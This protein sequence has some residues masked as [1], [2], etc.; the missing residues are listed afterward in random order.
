MK[1]LRN[2]AIHRVFQRQK[3]PMLV[4]LTERTQDQ[5]IVGARSKHA[6]DAIVR[7]LRQ[8]GVSCD[9]IHP[10]RSKRQRVGAFQAYDD[11]QLRVLV[12][13]HKYLIS[14]P[15]TRISR[16]IF[17]DVPHEH[18]YI[19]LL[20]MRPKR[21][22]SFITEADLTTL[23]EI[24]SIFERR[25]EE[26]PVPRNLRRLQKPSRT[27]RPLRGLKRSSVETPVAT[28]YPVPIFPITNAIGS[29]KSTR[30]SQTV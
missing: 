16:L 2:H 5:I 19:R 13:T 9:G 1:P 28:N 15:E 18:E 22:V 23:F 6:V 8:H 3:L 21:T 26:A 14:M 17:A 10:N 25:L 20:T 30:T 7:T 29:R 12:S 4:W 11:G 27:S 24:E